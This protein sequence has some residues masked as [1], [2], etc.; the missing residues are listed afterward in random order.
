MSLS[1]HN[2]RVNVNGKVHSARVESRRLLSD[3]LRDDLGLTGVHVGCEHG[4]CGTCTIIFNGE[5]SRSCLF[6]AVQA[7]GATI[8][9][10]EGLER[11]GKIHPIQQ[12][13]IE[14]NAFQ[15]GF[16]TPGMIMTSYALLKEIPHPSDDE[17]KEYISGN[18]CRCT[19]YV[20]IIEA[21]HSAASKEPQ[22]IGRK[23]SG[24]KKPRP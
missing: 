10:L 19:G 9:T 21:I 4:I 15:C 8:L 14:K 6:F 23:A 5:L 13:F 20:N 12:A 22:E 24:S 7:D 17:I 16:C 11:N 3:F 2:I 18:L 1:F